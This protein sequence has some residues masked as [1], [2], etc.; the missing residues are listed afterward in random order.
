MDPWSLSFDGHVPSDERLREALLTLGNGFFA[1]RGAIEEATAD[2]IHYPGTYLAGGYNRLLSVVADREIE[3]EDLVNWPNWLVLRFRVDDHWFTLDDVTLLEYK[4]ELDIRS[5]LLR[6]RL[7]FRDQ[8]GRESLLEVRRFVSMDDPHVGALEWSITPRNWSGIVAIKSAVDCGVVNAGVDRYRSL[9]GHHLVPLER[10]W[11]ADGVF[12]VSHESSQ[13]KLR[14]VQAIRTAVF[15]GGVRGAPRTVPLDENSTVGV[16]LHQHVTE[17]EPLRIEKTMCLYTS[18]DRSISEPVYEALRALELLPGFDRLLE[19][20]A[21]EWARLWKLCDIDLPGRI[22]E[23]KLLRLHLFHLLQTVSLKTLDLDVGVP[24]RGLHGEAYRGHIFWD[25][26]FIIPFLNLRIPELSRALLM[27]RY[28]RLGE[29]RINAGLAGFAGA[30]FPWQSG[31]NGEEENQKFHLNPVSG[32]WLPD[33]THLQRHINGAIVYNVWHYY[34]STEDRE[35]LSHFGM[36]LALDICRFFVSAFTFS[37]EKGRFVLLGVIGP[38]EFHTHDPE[39]GAPGVNNN[40]YTN[41]LASWCIRVSV[42]L[43]LTLPEDRQIELLRTLELT[44]SELNDWLDLSRRIYLPFRDG[45]LLPFE[46][47]EKLEDWRAYTVKYGN[48]QR[49]DRILEAEGD[50]VNHYHVSKQADVLMLFYL[51]SPSEFLEGLAWLG[52]P[53]A[54][55]GIRKNIEHHRKVT[56]HGSSLSR[57]VHAWV[58]ARYDG[59]RAWQLFDQAL[60]TDVADIQGGTTA[61]GIHLGA[62][63]GTLDLIQRCFTGLEVGRDQLSISPSFPCELENLR[64][65]IHYRGHALSLAIAN[66]VLEVSVK[67]S[68][69]PAL[70]LEIQGTI[71]EVREGEQITIPLGPCPVGQESLTKEVHHG[72][73]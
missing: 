6:R 73:D 24:A 55:G 58:L 59:S 46:G 56:T 7:R 21:K 68:H 27:Y 67:H 29:A 60:E 71:Y 14:V 62:M 54:P 5:G 63:A 42:D 34:Q 15:Q 52:Y 64:T 16:V 33:D 12:L 11:P 4:Q 39:T 38:D 30:M 2:E 65:V 49:L 32:N 13:S 26:L 18:R 37:E 23:T 51:F 36:E 22:R 72:F 50:T 8:K 43:F 31:S 57:I 66:G 19:R 35:F 28:R 45:V 70:K 25:E 10:R 3:N 20:H 53:C 48:L 9:N 61:E 1:T 40:A 17:N 41:Y 47:A 44:R 69:L